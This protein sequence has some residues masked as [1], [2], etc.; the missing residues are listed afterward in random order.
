MKIKFLSSANDKKVQF[1]RKNVYVDVTCPLKNDV[2]TWDCINVPEPISEGGT[3]YL[4]LGCGANGLQIA[5][6]DADFTDER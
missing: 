4:T 1:Y 6:P 2:C 5:I 3:T